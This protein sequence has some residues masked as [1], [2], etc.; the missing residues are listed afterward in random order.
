MTLK[1]NFR[2][3]LEPPPR[4]TLRAGRVLGGLWGT[5]MRQSPTHSS[6][7]LGFQGLVN[8]FFFP[9]YMS[10]KRVLTM[11]ALLAVLH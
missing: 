4:A 1:T 6:S 9:P 10:D 7:Y 5:T 8:I 3:P 2:T 11:C